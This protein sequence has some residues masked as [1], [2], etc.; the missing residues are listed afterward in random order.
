MFH[1]AFQNKLYHPTQEASVL[2][3]YVKDFQIS[4]KCY[5][6]LYLKKTMVTPLKKP[7]IHW[8]VIQ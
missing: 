3:S 7:V 1:I 2:L 6:N 8:K 4:N 5:L